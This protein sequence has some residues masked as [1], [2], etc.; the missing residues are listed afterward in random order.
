VVECC[1]AGDHTA[2]SVSLAMGVISDVLQRHVVIVLNADC[3]MWKS[4][5]FRGYENDW[6]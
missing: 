4:N 1:Q 6:L 5:S 2:Y 3:A